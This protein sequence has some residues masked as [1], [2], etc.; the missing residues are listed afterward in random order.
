SDA[1]ERRLRFRYAAL[2][3]AL[4]APLL[5]AFASVRNLYPFAASTEMMAGGDLQAGRT[6]YVM[7]G[8]TVAGETFDLPPAELTDALAGRAWSLVA[9]T[10]E[11][12]SF[13]I[14]SPHPSNVALTVSAGGAEK[15]PRGA[16]LQDLLRAW[17]TI[18]NSRLPASSTL[19]LRAV[20]L[21]EYRWEGKG[22]GDYEHFIESWRAEL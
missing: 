2:T 18:Y 12:G 5:F 19:R 20:R 4:F 11:N 14:P 1:S 6:Y 8:E 17:G 15:L 21:D 7:R 13:T 22:Y 16:R 10:V 9:A 3:V